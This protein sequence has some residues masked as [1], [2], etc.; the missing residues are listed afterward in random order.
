MFISFLIVNFKRK[1]YKDYFL[2]ELMEEEEDLQKFDQLI[3]QSRKYSNKDAEEKEIRERKLREQWE[4]KD[5]E[6]LRRKKKKDWASKMGVYRQ[7]REKFKENPFYM[8]DPSSKDY[9]QLNREIMRNVYGDKRFGGE[10]QLKAEADELIRRNSLEGA[11]LAMD[12]YNELGVVRRPS[13]KKKL[14]RFVERNVKRYSP[15][16]LLELRSYLEG[17]SQKSLEN[18]TLAIIGSIGI[19]ISLFF[20]SPIVTGHSIGNFIL[21]DSSIVGAVCFFLGLF[22]LFISFKNK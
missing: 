6:M 8:G 13:V 15:N 21:N 10:V 22:I 2:K 20:L 17:A 7:S 3:N 16:E 14:I 18:K 5:Q 12:Y 11:K 19:I 9:V 4:R 1:N